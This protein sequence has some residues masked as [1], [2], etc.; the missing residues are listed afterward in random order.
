MNKSLQ[1]LSI[2]SCFRHLSCLWQSFSLLQECSRNMILIRLSVFLQLY[3]GA[4]SLHL[5]QVL[6]PTPWHVALE[7]RGRVTLGRTTSTG[8]RC[9]SS[10]PSS[11]GLSRTPAAATGPHTAR[12]RCRHLRAEPPSWASTASVSWLPG[13]S[14]APSSGPETSHTSQSCQCQSRSVLVIFA[15]PVY[16]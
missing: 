7:D 6:V 4:G 10:S 3:S 5:T 12:H 1:H 9:Q 2:D 16:N 15:T 13:F 11:F 14:S 8:S